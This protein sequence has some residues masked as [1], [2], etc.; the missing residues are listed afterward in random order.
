MVVQVSNR[1]WTI[2]EDHLS[3]P[4]LKAH[5]MYRLYRQSW[6]FISTCMGVTKSVLVASVGSNGAARKVG[7]IRQFRFGNLLGDYYAEKIQ[8]Q[9]SCRSVR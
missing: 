7:K 9:V 6:L 3:T 8:P 4:A 2:D 5:A 1:E